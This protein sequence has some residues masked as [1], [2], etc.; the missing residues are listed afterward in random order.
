MNEGGLIQSGFHKELD[1]LREI[2]SSGKS[3]IA[4]LESQ[5]REKTG[6]PSLKVRYNKVFGY[7]IEVTKRHLN[8]VPAYY[9]RKQSL[10]ACER[11]VTPEL[12]DCEDKIL[13]AE[14]RI[15]DL[16]KDLFVEVRNQVGKQAS[17]IQRTAQLI[18]RL[19]TLLSLAEAARK[20]RYVRPQL[21][22]TGELSIHAGRH[23]VVEL[24]GRQPFI[25]NDLYCS[26]GEDQLLILTGPNMGGKSTYLRQNALIVILSQLGSFVPAEEAPYRTG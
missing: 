1:E 11:F 25:S 16:E 2:A 23:P 9:V 14:E 19:D 3:F 22:D 15:F 4:Q 21:D 12:K 13:S 10:V 20:Y 18:A 26:T 6:I 5:E 7:F 17:R 8:S 24:Q